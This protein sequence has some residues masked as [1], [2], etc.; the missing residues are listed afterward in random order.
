MTQTA[1]KV[2]KNAKVYS[3]ALDGTE[4]RAEAIAIKDGKFSYIG[5]DAGVKEWIGDATEVV[6]CHGKSIMTV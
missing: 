6:D 4:T 5:D 2:Y 1:D 3:I